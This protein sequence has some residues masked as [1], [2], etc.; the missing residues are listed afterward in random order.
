MRARAAFTL[1]E[2]LLVAIIAGLLAT[3]VVPGL[4]NFR[5]RAA[6]K[7]VPNVVE[8][9]RAA[10]LYS[11]QKTGSYVASFYWQYP[12]VLENNLNIELPDGSKN[13]CDYRV[14]EVPAGSGVF[15]IEFRPRGGGATVG[16]CDI[17]TGQYIIDETI[18]YG[19]YLEYLE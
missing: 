3:L 8:V 15:L 13:V 16:S 18:A 11:F 19:L 9:I 2:L 4:E 5:T 14:Q 1:I 7:E 6:L 10:E 17:A 12:G